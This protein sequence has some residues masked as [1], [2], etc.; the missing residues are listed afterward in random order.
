MKIIEV[1]GCTNCPMVVRLAKPGYLLCGLT[2]LAG[3]PGHRVLNRYGELPRLDK[4]RWCPLAKEDLLVRLGRK[5]S[6]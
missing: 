5:G 6:G 3:R 4:P 1:T 2:R